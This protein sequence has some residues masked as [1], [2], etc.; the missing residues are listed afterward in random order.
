MIVF[1]GIY[2]LMRRPR[3]FVAAWRKHYRSIKAGA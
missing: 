3:Y 1:K 2:Y